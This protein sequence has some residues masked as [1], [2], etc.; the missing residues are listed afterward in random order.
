[1]KPVR[2]V[3]RFDEPDDVLEV[4]GVRS[5]IVSL[6]GV[7]VARNVHQP[8]FCWSR[9]VKP[10]VR[11]DWCQTHHTGFALAG[12]LTVRLKSGEEFEILE[13]D[14]FDIPPG[15]DAW[16]VG[17]RPVESIEWTGVRSWIPTL[18]LLTERVLATLLFTDIVDST[19]TANRLGDSVW[20]DLIGTH[21][22]R[23]GD[24]V[25][26]YRGRQVKTTGDGVLA[27]FDS[28]ARA[29]RCALALREVASAFHLRIRAAVH[30]GE[31][32]VVDSDLRGRAVHEASRILGLAAPSEILVSATTKDLL[33]E[34]DF[35]LEDRG[36][37]QLRGVASARRLYAVLS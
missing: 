27:V 11:T 31:V 19:K 16:V 29:L 15:H 20:G 22:Q 10:L 17:D 2:Y 13:G 18:D 35:S 25:S 4:E 28:P 5:M 7:A 24:T 14:I 34:N 33:G 21:L 12:R 1:M 9:H 8:G 3:R 37:H 26:H 6:G 23:V 30:T 36:E 32:E